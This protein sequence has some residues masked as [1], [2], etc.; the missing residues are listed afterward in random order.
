MKNKFTNV[1]Y[2]KTQ[3]RIVCLSVWSMKTHG[4]LL[5][6]NLSRK[7]VFFGLD[8]KHISKTVYL[9]DSTDPNSTL[10]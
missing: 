10:F 8:F 9:P 4:N 1:G 7:N 5:I 3:F 6:L 2:K